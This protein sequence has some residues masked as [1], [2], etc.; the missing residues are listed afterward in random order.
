MEYAGWNAR[1]DGIPESPCDG[2]H[3]KRVAFLQA[4]LH[5]YHVAYAEGLEPGGAE[6]RDR[7]S[8]RSPGNMTTEG[9]DAQVRKAIVE[10]PDLAIL[11]PIS[12]EACTRWVGE[13][14]AAR[15]PRDRGQL[16]PQRG[17]L[18]D[19]P[20][21]VRARRLGPVPDAR[22]HLRPDD[23]ILRRVRD[24]PPHTGN[25]VL[26][27]AHLVGHHGAAPDRP[28]DEVP[29][30]GPQLAGRRLRSR[31]WRSAW[32]SGWIE[33][34][35]S[36]LRGIVA[37][38]DDIVV[39]GI[40]EA[41]RRA[42]RQDII[43]VGAGS[44][45]KGMQAVKAGS[46]HAITFQPPQAD[47]ALPLK[48]AVDWFNGLDI[49]PI[50]YLPKHIITRDN[51]DDFISKKPEFSPVS[52]DGLTRAVLAQSDSEVDRFFEDAY[53]NFLSAEMVTPEVF[54][55]FSIEVLSD[56]YPCHEDE[57]PGRSRAAQRLRK[58]LQE[59]LQPEDAPQCHGMDEAA[60][61]DRHPRIGAGASGGEPDRQDHPL[62]DA[63]L[64]RAALAEGP[65][66]RSTESRRPTW[67]A[68]SARRWASHSRRT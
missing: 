52:L 32:S 41:L 60:L 21:L 46:L 10:K 18:P 44:T 64:R 5:P 15:H 12:S 57:R 33:A 68:S 3:G 63:Q 54:R 45:P 65:G 22:A 7:G 13:F 1:K 36:D 43:R 31:R 25:L 29:C 47:G 4:G 8:S 9:Q 30:H 49:Q 28:E 67:A 26:L 55:G 38:D 24:S 39:D 51:V 17:R 14:H 37:P 20:R 6:E 48:I 62:R 16:H 19:H 58:P 35:G 53:V 23:G 61:P 27:R 66:R 56:P 2:P 42:G 50:N 11:V 59:P 34:Y 40:D